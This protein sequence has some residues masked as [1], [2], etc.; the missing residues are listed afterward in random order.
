MATPPSATAAEMFHPPTI[1]HSAFGSAT[2]E[3][4]SSGR[5][6]GHAVASAPRVA[7]EGVQRRVHPH[8]R[9]LSQRSLRHRDT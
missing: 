8:D 3:R 7:V 5:T 9:P 2:E 1:P 4:R 6:G